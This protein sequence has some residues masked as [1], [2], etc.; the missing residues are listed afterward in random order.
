MKVQFPLRGLRRGAL[1]TVGVAPSVAW[2]VSGRVMNLSFPVKDS[3]SAGWPPVRVGQASQCRPG[4][5]L[6]M[7]MSL[8]QMSCG[9]SREL[10]KTLLGFGLV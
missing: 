7:T 4:C 2:R 3:P 5:A 9:F 10:C 6:Q 1:G 8:G